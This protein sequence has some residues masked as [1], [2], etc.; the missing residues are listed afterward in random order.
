MSNIGKLC[1][2]TDTVIQN[3]YSHFEIAKLAIKGGA[4]MIQFRDKNMPTAKMIETA[5]RVRILCNKYNVTFIVNDRV[6]VALISNADGVHLG[7][8]DI[9]IKEAIKLLGKNKIIGAT[10]HSLKEA[11]IAEEQGADYIGYG[12][13][14]H[15]TTKIKNDD[16][17]GLLNLQKILNS[18][19][20]P[21][22]AIGGINKKNI[23][24]VLHTLVYGVAVSG[25]VAKSKNP[26]E[27]VKV[28]HNLIFNYLYL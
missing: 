24:S 28:F 19:N 16:P 23:E 14:F 3:K 10:A 18:I 5:I 6:D 27:T 17:K 1:V 11:K 22:L 9:P 4:D 25:A 8:D 7:K 2:I 26:A 20:I 13:I 21:V 12:H 15:T